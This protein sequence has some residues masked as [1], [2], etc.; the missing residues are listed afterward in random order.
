ME[1]LVFGV[2]A[3]SALVLGAL[4]GVRFRLPKRLLAAL[5]AFASGALITALAF[6]LFEDAYEHGGIWRAVLGLV[7]GAVVFTVLSARLDRAARGHREQPHGSEKLDPDAA[8]SDRAPSTASMTGAAGLA[9]LAAVTLDGVPEN[10]ALGVSLGEGTGGLALLAAIFVSNFP[11]ALVGSASMRAQGRS[12]RFVLGTWTACAALLV[13]AV[14]LGAGP[15]ANTTPETI[16]LPLAFAA[17]AV[18]AS[19]ADTLMPEAYEKGGPAVAL[20]TTAG[21]VLSFALATL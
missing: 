9:L 1:A 5:L 21:F 17:G 14:L 13:L 4:A 3:S 16:S 8:A 10:V 15:L 2:V 11:E 7:A 19:L 18:L 12:R 20:S 6:E